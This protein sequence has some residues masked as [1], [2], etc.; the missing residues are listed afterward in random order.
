MRAYFSP[1]GI[2]LGHVGRCILIAKRLQKKRN[3][4]VMFSTYREGVHYVRRERF[5]FVEAP[6]IGFQVKPDGAIDFRQTAINPGPFL[7]SF[8]L[9]RQVNAEIKFIEE[10]APDV[11][12]S[13]SR[14]SSLLA[15][16]ILQIPRICILN[17]FQVIIPRRKRFLRLARFADSATLTII[18]KI[19]T[20]GNAVLIP[21]YPQPYTVSMG[22]LSVPNSYRR[23]IRLIGPILPTC[24]ED[25]PSKEEIRKRLQIPV[26]KLTI[27][28]PISG[29]STERT[30]LTRM[31]RKILPEF[32]KSYE[33]ILSLGYPNAKT[34]PIHQGNLRIYKWVP[35]RFDYLKACDLVVS[36]SGHG[37]V[38]QCMYYGKPMILIPTPNHT[39]Q[40]NNAKQTKDLGVAQILRQEDLSK[41]EL[42]NKTQSMLRSKILSRVEEIQQ[43]VL[44]YNG[45]EEASKTIIEA[46]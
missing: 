18:G 27:F 23:K 14:A 21:D 37:T 11:V 9:I 6:P 8:T 29:P 36:R 40:L 25:L 12:V 26:D 24:P 45:L 20:D 44:E 1:C 7:A 33:I 4:E 30:F 5:R 3:A 17:Q 35:N 32:P 19:W 31:L 15:A 13:D 46:T 38:T 10:F 22:N 42:L 2:G 41:Q 34:E 28:V 43:E 39:E 16:K